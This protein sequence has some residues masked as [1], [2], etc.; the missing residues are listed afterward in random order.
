MIWTTAGSFYLGP[1]LV[2]EKS[3]C[4][5]VSSY[6]PCL[7][8]A[9]VWIEEGW[10]E[11]CNPGEAIRGLIVRVRYR[12]EKWL[13]SFRPEIPHVVSAC[14][15]HRL[16]PRTSYSCINVSGLSF[17]PT[18]LGI[19]AAHCFKHNLISTS[20]SPLWQSR[21][22]LRLCFQNLTPTHYHLQSD[23]LQRFHNFRSK[24]RRGV[25]CTSTKDDGA[26]R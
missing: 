9:S 5:V 10:W 19:D 26:T 4:E 7:E 16:F 8:S 22:H 20:H 15:K 11:N 3:C 2:F 24:Q 14:R 21:A 23:L 6:C 12:L 25:R 18:A 17:E 13:I 1:D